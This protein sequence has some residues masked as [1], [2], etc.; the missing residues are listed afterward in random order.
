MRFALCLTALTASLAAAQPGPVVFSELMWMGSTASSADEW[1]ELYNRG[2]RE[3]DLTGWTI[4]RLTAEGEQVMLQVSAGKVA[5]GAVFLIANYAARDANS[6]L[7]VQAD[8]VDAAIA[9]PNTKLQLRLYD[10]DPA[11]GGRLADVAD[12]GTGAP[13]AGDGQLKQAMVRVAF[14]RDGSQREAWATAVESSGWDAGAAELGTP[15]SLHGTGS[16]AAG[17]P[18]SGTPVGSACWAFVK[19][20]R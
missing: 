19:A 16:P 7:A 20:G 9:L 2:D 18:T 12:D 15:G 6:L 5:A 8:L 10:G 14:D 13:A 3:V 1:I 4:T 11:A 17:E